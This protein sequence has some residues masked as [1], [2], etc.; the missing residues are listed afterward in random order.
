MQSSLECVR[1]AIDGTFR[2]LENIKSTDKE[3]EII[4]KTIL[5]HLSTLDMTT[6]PVETSMYIH[7]IIKKAFNWASTMTWKGI[8]PVVKLVKKSYEKGIKLTKKE[9]KPYESRI[10]R[11]NT[12]PKWDV[13]IEPVFAPVFA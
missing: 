8:K 3:K 9:M 10:I 6:P 5:N 13:I 11:S 12:L 2:M 4:I 1:C 7:R